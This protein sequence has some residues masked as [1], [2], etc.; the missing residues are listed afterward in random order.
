MA[1]QFAYRTGGDCVAPVK[2]FPSADAK[3]WVKGEMANMEN[4]LLDNGAA[5]DSDIVGIVNA[6]F[7]AAEG[8]PV[9]IV[10]ALDDVVFKAPYTGTTKTSLDDGDIGTAFD[11]DATGDG[12]N[13]DDTTDGMWVCVGYDNDAE[14]AFVKLLAA[15]RADVVG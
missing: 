15:E 11:Y 2:T 7:T 5:A 6:G 13:L 9:E 3:T 14:V 1:F 10:L 8:D 12:I 4:G